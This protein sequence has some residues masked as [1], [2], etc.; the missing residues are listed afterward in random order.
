MRKRHK[1]T[2]IPLA[3][4]DAVQV[5]LADW[6][7]RNG[8]RY[9]EDAMRCFG[10]KLGKLKVM[11]NVDTL[12][13]NDGR[14]STHKATATDAEGMAG[15]FIETLEQIR[16]SRWQAKSSSPMAVPDAD[17]AGEIAEPK[18]NAAVAS[19]ASNAAGAPQSDTRA[20]SEWH[21]ARHTNAA[22]VLKAKRHTNDGSQTQTSSATTD[23]L[24]KPFTVGLSYG[25]P[26][27]SRVPESYDEWRQ[28]LLLLMR[29][30]KRARLAHAA[31]P[32]LG[33]SRILLAWRRDRQRPF[34]STMR[35]LNKQIAECRKHVGPAPKWFKVRPATASDA[36]IRRQYH[37]V[38]ATSPMWEWEGE[39]GYSMPGYPGHWNINRA[40]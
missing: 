17:N 36:R 30:L 10:W 34:A 37:D 21:R 29:C 12:V 4:R 14:V 32:T 11:Y 13:V 26:F 16:D 25:Q 39:E 1:P 3:V 15:Q 8:G 40:A 35:A 28:W 22:R 27:Y 20:S 18:G 5:L 24:P 31:V 9:R 38:A 19:D 23:E 33:S 6:I 2:A 7:C